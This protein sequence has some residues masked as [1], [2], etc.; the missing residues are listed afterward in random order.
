[1]GGMSGTADGKFTYDY[2]GTLKQF[3][4]SRFGKVEFFLDEIV[5]GF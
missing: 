1:M 5:H 4:W 2:M 3:V